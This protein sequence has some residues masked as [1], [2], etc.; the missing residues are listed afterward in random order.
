M[1]HRVRIMAVF[2]G[3][4]SV[5]LYTGCSGPNL[6]AHWKFDEGTGSTAVDFSGNG[7][8]GTITGLRK[9]G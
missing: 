3:F 8:N 4:G 6:I 7:N 1:M 9:G 5:R 2:G